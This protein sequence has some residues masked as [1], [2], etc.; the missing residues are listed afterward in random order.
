M[1]EG[2]GDKMEDDMMAA[3][4][5]EPDDR[6]KIERV[7]TSISVQSVLRIT[8][9]GYN[10]NKVVARWSQGCHIGVATLLQPCYVITNNI[11]HGVALHC[12]Y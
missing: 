7:R 6:E 12:R 8:F 3:E 5:Q 10:V 9:I 1:E 4:P 11:I 2:E